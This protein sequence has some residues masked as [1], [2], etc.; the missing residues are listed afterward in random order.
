MAIIPERS[1]P[2]RPGIK[3]I[4]EIRLFI[5]LFVSKFGWLASI[6]IAIQHTNSTRI[7]QVTDA[8]QNEFLTW[9]TSFA[10]DTLWKIAINSENY[11]C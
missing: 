10:I 8:I 9:L 6:N 7:K 5:T 4:S 3:S 2:L 1:K 11:Y